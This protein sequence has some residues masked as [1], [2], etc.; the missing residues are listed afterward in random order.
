M[1]TTNIGLGYI[2]N[3]YKDIINRVDFVDYPGINDGRNSIAIEFKDVKPSIRDITEFVESLKPVY[4]SIIE[5]IDADILIISFYR[6]ETMIDILY[7]LFGYIRS[8]YLEV[9]E[10]PEEVPDIFRNID[11]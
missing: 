6:D 3:E 10:E 2:L 7:T 1:N 5:K 8:K 9:P 4:Q 11:L